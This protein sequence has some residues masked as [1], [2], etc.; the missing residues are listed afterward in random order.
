MKKKR[1]T[2]EEPKGRFFKIK[3]SKSLNCQFPLFAKNALFAKIF[4]PFLQ[5]RPFLQNYFENDFH[6]QKR[7]NLEELF[8]N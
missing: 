2:G 7:L 5:K 1:N 4:S 3:S 6:F 8:S